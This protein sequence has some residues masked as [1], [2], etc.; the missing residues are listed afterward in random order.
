MPAHVLRFLSPKSHDI[1][2]LADRTLCSPQRQQWNGGLAAAV[3]L[4][5]LDVNRSGGSIIF[6]DCVDAIGF[7]SVQMARAFCMALALPR[8]WRRLASGR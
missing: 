8:N 3:G 1:E 7:K 2:Q 5:L 4:Y 6:A